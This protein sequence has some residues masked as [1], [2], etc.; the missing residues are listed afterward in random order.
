MSDACPIMAHQPKYRRHTTRDLGFVEHAGKR[1]YFCGPYGS[2]QSRGEYYEFL[3]SLGFRVHDSAPPI[4]GAVTLSIMA[5]RF[6][7]W[8]TSYYPAGPKSRAVNL[9]SVLKLLARFTSDIPAVEFTPLRLKEF[10][11]WL[12]AQTGKNKRKL[13]RRYINDVCSDLRFVFKWAVSEELIPVATYQSLCTVPGLKYGRTEAKETAPR[14][15]IPIETIEATIRALNPMVA[16]MVEFQ[17]LTGA[18]SQSLCAATPEQFDKS[19]NPWEWRPL[20]KTRHLGHELVLFVGPKAQK[21]IAP[22]MKGRKS[23]EFIFR[24]LNKAGKRSKNYRAFYDSDSYRRAIRR[25]LIQAKLPHWFPHLLRHTRGT[26][27]R[28]EHGLEAA[29][30]ALGHARIDATQI[31]AQKQTALAKLVAETMG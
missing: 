30:A 25:A 16:A 24:P 2:H 22:L 21:I 4:E 13:S 18:R 10:Q 27:V 15:P 6:V 23:L 26:D 14:K 31:Y 19:K 9:Q 28:Q 29:Q 20:H 7:E 12:V 3:K 17:R 5:S 8:S 11:A 1:I